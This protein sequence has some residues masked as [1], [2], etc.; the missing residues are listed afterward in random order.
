MWK[1]FVMIR[2]LLNGDIGRV[3]DIWL[4]TNLKTHYFI[5]NQ[6]WK[7]NYELV[8]EMMSQS[9]VYV[10]EVD[11]MIIILTTIFFIAIGTVRDSRYYILILVYIIVYKIILSFTNRSK[12]K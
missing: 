9:E 5:S 6:Y 2:K 1:I 4:K 7:S 12:K 10:F 11:K 3:A 8:K